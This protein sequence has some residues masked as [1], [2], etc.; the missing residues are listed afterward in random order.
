M[1]KLMTD[2]KIDELSSVLASYDMCMDNFYR[3]LLEAPLNFH[4]K[5]VSD[6][7][8]RI[9]I[10]VHSIGLMLPAVKTYSPTFLSIG[11]L[12][13]TIIA[14]FITYC[15]LTSL[16]KAGNAKNLKEEEINRIL[17]NEINILDLAYVKAM[18]AAVKL[19]GQLPQSNP[20]FSKVFENKDHDEA[21]N[22]IKKTYSQFFKDGN[23][24]NAYKGVSDFRSV[25]SNKI[26]DKDKIKQDPKESVM[27]TFASENGF[28]KYTQSYLLFRFYSQFQHY[29]SHSITL[30]K[31]HLND[32]N[33]FYLIFTLNYAFIASDMILQ[34]LRPDSSWISTL[35][36]VTEDLGH[37]LQ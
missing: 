13:R 24:E 15:Y 35:R 33:F 27:H 25:S 14:D 10:N 22:R 18:I 30:I 37:V 32:Y 12:N 7:L 8:A 9:K 16:L 29:S 23:P 31:P 20:Q 3:S 21:I 2:Q 6:L 26:F 1:K 17:E 11:L 19:E 36:G 5:I 4:Q 28:A 34:N